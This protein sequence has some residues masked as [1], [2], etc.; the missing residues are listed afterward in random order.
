[1]TASQLLRGRDSSLRQRPAQRRRAP[2][3]ARARPAGTWGGGGGGRGR[4]QARARPR[5]VPARASAAL[6]L[7]TKGR[8][9]S[10][11]PPQPL[12]TPDAPAHLG[13]HLL[14]ALEVVHAVAAQHRVEGAGAKA[15]QLGVGVEVLLGS[16]GGWGVGGIDGA[17]LAGWRGGPG[18]ARAM[19]GMAAAAP[20]AR[21]VRRPPLGTSPSPAPPD[22]CKNQSSSAAFA[23]SSSAH[24][25]C[26]VTARRAPP[27]R[28][29]GGRCDAQLLQRSSTRSGSGASS[30]SPRA[31]PASRLLAATS[32]STS[33]YRSAAAARGVLNQRVSRFSQLAWPGTAG[34][35]PRPLLPVHSKARR[36]RLARPRPHPSRAP[37]S[38]APRARRRR[39]ARRRRTPPPAARRASRGPRRSAAAWGLRRG[40]GCAQG[41][42]RRGRVRACGTAWR[43][44]GAWESS[45]AGSSPDRMGAPVSCMRPSPTRRRG[46]AAPPPPPPPSPVAAARRGALRGRAALRAAPTRARIRGR[47]GCGG[48]RRVW[49]RRGVRRRRGRAGV[50]AVASD[51]AARVRRVGRLIRARPDPPPRAI[52]QK[53]AGLRPQIAS[54][55]SAGCPR[56]A[57][58]PCRS[59]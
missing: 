46:P 19:Q 40:C 37:G 34:L 50:P 4:A 9:R 17:T 6:P 12:C 59:P 8:G 38:R 27:S 30:A 13:R 14:E 41:R 25:P 33:A 29:G 10:A 32:D 18:R 53:P 55:P 7:R 24:T 45:W 26:P 39:A 54:H 15:A 43:S 1:V 16:G 47:A 21:P 57:G 2:A 42:G 28:P 35:A 3:P 22:T 44:R 49:V 58:Q 51:T 48:A 23:A 5:G 20:R 31:A 52:T 11:P 56:P 36:A